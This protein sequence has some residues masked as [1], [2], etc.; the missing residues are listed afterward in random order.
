[1]NEPTHRFCS[2]DLRHIQPTKCCV[3]VSW[4]SSLHLYEQ[5]R[6]TVDCHTSEIA[7]LLGPW[8]LTTEG[9]KYT[10]SFTIQ[11]NCWKRDTDT[12]D[13]GVW[14]NNYRPPCV[15]NTEFS[16]PFRTQ[17]LKCI[18]FIFFINI[19]AFSKMQF[20]TGLVFKSV[21]YCRLANFSK[22]KETKSRFENRFRL[23]VL[24]RMAVY[25]WNTNIA[26]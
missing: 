21:I 10:V 7:L 9:K 18:F 17:L 24:A 13:T 8:T 14:M 20:S 12:Q 26:R 6:L 19:T 15:F 3:L 2:C 25:Q 4:L 22:V 5:C 11:F 16:T 23:S 1:M